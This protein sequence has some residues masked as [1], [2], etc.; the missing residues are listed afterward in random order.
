[1]THGYGVGD[2]VGIAA[3]GP[4][5]QYEITGVAAF[6]SVDS[7]GGATIAIFDLP[8]AQALFQKEGRFDA[9]SVAAKEGVSPTELVSQLQPL[10]P[11]EAEVTTGDA[12]AAAESEN[13]SSELS[14]ITYILLGFGGVAL[15]V[16]AFV[17]FNT[18]SITVAQ[19][20]REFA[21][22]RTLGGSRRQVLRSVILEGF[23]V[24]LV[25]GIVGLVLG[26]G[27]AKGMNALFVAFG[28][29]LP[30]TG[31]VIATRTI[32]VSLLVGTLVT[33]LASIVPAVRATRVP[34]I[35]AVREGSTLPKSR[36]S[37]WAALR[38]ARR[39]SPC[40]S[41]LSAPGCSSKAWERGTCCSCSGSA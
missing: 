16:G 40:R 6:G 23:I 30:Q 25:A 12:R 36:L 28:I 13:T 9:I 18:L 27:L 24:G 33:V 5:K 17:I 4:V 31:T 34:P 15:F 38:G 39:R 26:V 32:V 10:L 8:T 35:L 22:L 21:T 20:T 37:P 29:D 14:S 41:R 2:T 11:P 3:L 19:R 7:I 1:M